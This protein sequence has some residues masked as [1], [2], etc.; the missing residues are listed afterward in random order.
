MPGLCSLLSTGVH[1]AM[2]IVHR[3]R[4]QQQRYVANPP[5]GPSHTSQKL[6]ATVGGP[7][8]KRNSTDD[9][10]KQAPCSLPPP[11]LFSK[12]VST[13]RPTA[14]P[15]YNTITTTPTGQGQKQK[16]KARAQAQTG[17]PTP[18][19]G[20][21]FTI[22]MEPREWK[23]PFPAGQPGGSSSRT[24]ARRKDEPR[25]RGYTAAEAAQDYRH[26]ACFAAWPIEGDGGNWRSVHG[27]MPD[28]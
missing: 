18:R 2:G 12:G 3:S 9:Q 22:S 24:T 14:F 11:H 27:N 23:D 16:I 25:V 1:R 8:S 7:E 26:G 20:D 4:A 17:A 21:F 15:P 13:P 19:N 6:Q 28:E 10:A 5:S